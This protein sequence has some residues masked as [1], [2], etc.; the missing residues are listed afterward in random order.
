MSLW[1]PWWNA[2]WQLRPAFSRLRA[3]LWFAT[4][5][6]G[7]TVRTELLGVTSLVR[8]LKLDARCYNKLV[9]HFHSPA[10]QLDRLAAL[11]TQT[12]LR[13]FPQPLRVNGRCVVVGDGI[14][15]P[16]RGRKMPGVKLLHQQSESNTKPEYIM[17]H[18]LQA[19]SLLVHAA[20]SV[21]AVPLA[22][23]IH[24]GVV[25]SNRDR[26]TLLDKMLAL[27]G[28]AAIPAP[29][30]FVADAY[31]AARKIVAG[32]LKDNNHLV[33]RVKSNAVAYT[34]YQQRG[35]RKRGRPKVYDRKIK[36]K[37][38]LADPK[39]REHAKS[40]V[41]GE[42]QV[43]IHYKVC[44]LLWRPA[45]RLVRFVAVIHPTR[46][47]C[48]LMC[49]DT[50]LAAIEII[51]LY[52]LRF[53]IEHTFKQAVRLIGAFSY[54]F[55]MSDMKPVR[56][57]SGNQH[58]HRASP[59]YRDAVRRK[60]HAYHVFIQ[61]AVVCQ[62]LLQYLAVAFP[63][64]VWDAFGS[65][66]RTIRP[67]IPPSELVVANALRQSMPEFLLNSASGNSFA[68]FVGERQDTDKMEAF[69]LAS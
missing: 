24:E 2:I 67:G 35:P 53:K 60:L 32:L 43:V 3:F 56:R 23:R 51:R 42:R 61:A 12:V 5:V 45:G 15:V 1:I 10:V 62:G 59:E 48:L 30:Y 58:L 17:G 50:S 11:W 19:V 69:R 20:A 38:L 41:Y 34:P 16:K 6:A 26:R 25:W 22:V 28:T 13:L 54:H 64:R 7:F 55:W 18:S 39:G 9:D 21:F 47:S 14:K 40:P 31:Y 4:A 66:L 8:A 29:F 44:D 33:T 49:T 46:G 52:G 57:R 68:K 27:L 36:L 63:Q 65:W 37:S